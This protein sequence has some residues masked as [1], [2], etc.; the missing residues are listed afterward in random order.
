M[1]RVSSKERERTY[2]ENERFVREERERQGTGMRERFEGGGIL[3][4][5]QIIKLQHI[6]R[7]LVPF[8][9]IFI[10]SRPRN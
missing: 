7:P 1:V 2:R 4:N 5:P 8:K 3:P 10:T 9:G 6:L